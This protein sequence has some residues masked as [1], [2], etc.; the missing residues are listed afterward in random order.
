MYV[1]SKIYEEQDRSQ[2]ITSNMSALDFL[3][4]RKIHLVIAMTNISNK[5]C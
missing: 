4:S 3:L 5:R 1:H 2:T